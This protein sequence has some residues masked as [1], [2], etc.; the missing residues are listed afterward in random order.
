MP[1][2]V[3]RG[4]ED[5]ES[6]CFLD[7]WQADLRDFETESS[8]GKQ[9]L[10]S[11][12]HSHIFFE[13]LVSFLFLFTLDVFTAFEDFKL[14]SVP[15]TLFFRKEVHSEK[16][17]ESLQPSITGAAKYPLLVFTLE[18][19]EIENQFHSISCLFIS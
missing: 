13:N 12:N 7:F 6:E 5:R 9:E 17:K 14:N 8:E 10:I 1:S 15:T 16:T 2:L 18:K 4:S 3:D 19:K 11:R